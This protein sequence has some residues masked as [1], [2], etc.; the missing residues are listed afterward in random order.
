MQD[1]DKYWWNKHNVNEKFGVMEFENNDF[2]DL[3]NLTVQ[4]IQKPSNNKCIIKEIS[5]DILF[6][7]ISINFSGVISWLSVVDIYY[8]FDY[9]E[10]IDLFQGESI[11]PDQYSGLDKYVDIQNSHINKCSIFLAINVNTKYFLKKYTKIILHELGHL[12]TNKN[13]KQYHLEN[14]DLI[15]HYSKNVNDIVEQIE[16]NDIDGL[17]ED[18]IWNIFSYVMYYT[19]LSESHAF[20][21]NINFEMLCTLSN[22]ANYK[23]NLKYKHIPINEYNMFK[24][25]SGVLQI[26][27]WLNEILECCDNVDENIKLSFNCKYSNE[28]KQVYGKS[29][30]YRR[31]LKRYQKIIHHVLLNSKKLYGYY[32]NLYD[33]DKTYLMENFVFPYRV[34]KRTLV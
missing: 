4:K 9:E 22:P 16:T 7:K 15:Y 3:V 11:V 8:S 1:F 28:I 13:L 25:S 14:K 2:H 12:Y 5:N 6:D 24:Y 23:L 10:V 26:Y 27:C 20:A 19:N 32:S 33:L 30:S 21:E 31:L 17:N 34:S 29:L 18:D